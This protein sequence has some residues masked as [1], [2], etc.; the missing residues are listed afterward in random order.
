MHYYLSEF[1]DVVVD[2]FG[3]LRVWVTTHGRWHSQQSSSS[4]SCIVSSGVLAGRVVPAVTTML[5]NIVQT[6]CGRKKSV[7]NVGQYSAND[8]RAQTRK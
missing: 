1:R 7:N 4:T 3:P 6:I 8:M 2:T 5:V